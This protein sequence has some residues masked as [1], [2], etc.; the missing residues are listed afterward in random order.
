M[1]SEKTSS[2]ELLFGWMMVLGGLLLIAWLISGSH[3]ILR[4][5]S[6]VFAIGRI[7]T[8]VIVDLERDADR[9]PRRANSQQ[10]TGLLSVV[11][12]ILATALACVFVLDWGASLHP[13]TPIIGAL[14]V[15]GLY[16]VWRRLRAL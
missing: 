8:F 9:G 14:L 15:V 10:L 1:A 2:L 12:V 13:I 7:G 5:A 3:A 16:L 6:V 4:F 11:G